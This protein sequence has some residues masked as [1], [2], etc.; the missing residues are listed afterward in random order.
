MTAALLAP[1]RWMGDGACTGTTW[2]DRWHPKGDTTE[3]ARRQAETAKA[4]CRGCPVRAECLA[5][6]QADPSLTG[7]WGGTTEQERAAM[8]RRRPGRKPRP[9]QPGGKTC[10]HC[11]EFLPYAEFH[12]DAAQRDGRGSWCKGCQKAARVAARARRKAEKG[13]AA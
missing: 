5:Y 9:T 3:E 8:R 11:R 2:P 6:A 7:V 13:A 1:P 12:R 10:T 4:V